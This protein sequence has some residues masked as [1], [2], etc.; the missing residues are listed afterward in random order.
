M[1]WLE[2]PQAGH[3]FLRI[4]FQSSLCCTFSNKVIADADMLVTTM[5]HW[6]LD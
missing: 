3:S 6:I 2:Y 1:S 4:E 5:M